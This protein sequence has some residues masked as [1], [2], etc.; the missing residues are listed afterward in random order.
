MVNPEFVE[1]CQLLFEKDPNSKVFAPL[2][3]AYRRMGLVDAA[4][5]VGRRGVSLHPTFA[6]G[7]LA[8]AKALF[9]KEA[10][11]EV[12]E[13]LKEVCE[14]SPE[15]LLAHNLMGEV[16]LK[17]RNPKAALKSF[18]MVLFL[19]AQ[20]E[21]ARKQVLRLEA[22]TADEYDEDVFAP[23]RLDILVTTHDE[24]TPEYQRELQRVV[25]LVDA[26]LGRNDA[27]K[28]ANLISK[29]L[30]TF[31]RHP[32]LMQRWDFLQE[33]A[34]EDQL[35]AEE[36]VADSNSGPT[37]KAE[38]L[39]PLGVSPSSGIVGLRPKDRKIRKLRSLLE[40]VNHQRL[41]Y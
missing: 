37:E 30:A 15:N 41:R 38:T 35:K 8:L 36:D 28:A 10:W 22:L 26:F 33:L 39:T 32:A 20:D 24:G 13:H 16:Y 34:A 21:R 31:G 23:A 40:R 14:L 17:L 11:D 5:Q 4:I 1:R 12:L 3:E 7:R 29:A 18:K 2:T 19:N 25:S 9:E 6:S 27:E